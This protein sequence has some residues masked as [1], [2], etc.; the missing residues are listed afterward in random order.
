MKNKFKKTDKIATNNFPFSQLDF[1]IKM[2]LEEDKAYKDITTNAVIPKRKKALGKIIAH[3][4]LVLCGLEPARRVFYLIDP[5]LEF[6][7]LKNEGEKVLPNEVVAEVRG[8]ARAILSGERL[9]LN[10]LQHLCGIATLTRKMVEAVNGTKTRV[11]ATRKTIPLFR[12]FQKYAVVVGGGL[13]HRMDLSDGILIKENHLAMANDFE[14]MIKTAKRKA[15]GNYKVEVEVN[16]LKH[17]KSALKAGA[18]I[19]M[20]DNMSVKEIKKAVK[21]AKGKVILEASGGVTLENIREIA[22]TGVDWISSG[23]LTHSLKASNLSLELE[24][25]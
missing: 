12:F 21:L 20:L 11:T 15:K 25:L 9:A 10:F 6:R 3:E 17:F 5:S 13:P 8:N 18:D 14:Q 4:E 2:A 19:I 16:N 24:P 7:V 1:F 23:A 22:L